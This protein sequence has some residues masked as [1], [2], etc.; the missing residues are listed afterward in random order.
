MIKDREVL[1][2]MKLIH[3]VFV[4]SIPLSIPVPLVASVVLL[5]WEFVEKQLTWKDGP[6]HD[7]D[8]R[9]IYV[10][11]WDIDVRVRDMGGDALFG[12]PL[13]QTIV[14]F[15]IMLRVSFYSD[16]WYCNILTY[17]PGLRDIL[18]DRRVI[19]LSDLGNILAYYPDKTTLSKTYYGYPA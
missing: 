8:E 18:S 1:T 12:C 2:A 14:I 19:C 16:I 4:A 10:V 5:V 13:L 6:N 11:T 7:F 9:N 17:Y 3:S 15:I